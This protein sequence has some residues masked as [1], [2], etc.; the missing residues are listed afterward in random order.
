MKIFKVIILLFFSQAC[1]AY[2]LV[3]DVARFQKSDGSLFEMKN[4]G[5]DKS[6]HVWLVQVTENLKVRLENWAA[7]DMPT[8]KEVLSVLKNCVQD[9]GVKEKIEV[10]AGTFETCKFANEV[11]GYTWIGD[12]PFSVVKVKTTDYELALFYL[13]PI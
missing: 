1:F 8:Q 3:G 9:S 10:P 6:N 12:V 13:S 7:D 4:T 2:P 11:G 5:F